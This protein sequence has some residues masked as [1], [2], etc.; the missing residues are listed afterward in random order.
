MNVASSPRKLDGFQECFLTG[1][2]AGKI[3][4][5]PDRRLEFQVGPTTRKISD[6]STTRAANCNRRGPIPTGCRTK[7]RRPCRAEAERISAVC[8]R[9]RSGT[10]PDQQ[11]TMTV[12]CPMRLRPFR[13]GAFGVET[14]ASIW[15]RA[16]FGRLATPTRRRGLVLGEASTRVVCLSKVEVGC[17]PQ[18]Q[19][20]TLL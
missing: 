1:T 19:S 5:W 20:N 9:L 7:M 15:T 13:R 17:Q 10:Q 16:P 4:C 3:P 11:A 2:A 18:I 14:T 12:T 6:D 8:G